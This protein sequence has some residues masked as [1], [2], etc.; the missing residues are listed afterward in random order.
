MGGIHMMWFWDTDEVWWGGGGLEPL[1]TDARARGLQEPAATCPHTLQQAQ[2][3]PGG[4]LETLQ[5]AIGVAQSRRDCSATE[6]QCILLRPSW[7]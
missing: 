7:L 2:P 6:T 1:I 4:K 3:Q 5:G